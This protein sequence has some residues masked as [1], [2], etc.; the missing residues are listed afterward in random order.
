[1]GLSA[2]LARGTLGRSSMADT[3]KCCLS[4][5]LAGSHRRND[6]AQLDMRPD[7]S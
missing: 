1:M 4:A 7:G 6:W 5:G 3:S 2:L